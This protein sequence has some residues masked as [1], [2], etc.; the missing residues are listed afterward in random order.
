MMAQEKT[1]KARFSSLRRSL[2]GIVQETRGGTLPMVAALMIPMV[3]GVGLATDA[4]RGYIVKAR[5]GDALDAATLAAA[6]TV[7]TTSDIDADIKKYFDANFPPGFM[8]AN[9][10]L[11]PAVVSTDMTTISVSAA[12]TIDATF[13]KVVNSNDITV[14]SG[15]QVT[16]AISSID[17][18]LSIDMSGSM[19][20]D[21]GTGQTR[22][23]A[24]RT[25][26]HVLADTVFAQDPT[27]N[28]VQVGVVPWNGKV[29]ILQDGGTYNPLNVTSVT[30]PSY[31]NPVA[32]GTSTTVFSPD[33][34]PVNL[35]STPA[36][37]WSGCVYARYLN[38][39]TA[40]D[41]DDRL[42]AVTVNGKDWVAWEPI[43][44]TDEPA[45]NGGSCS[46]CTPCLSHGVTRMTNNTTTVSDAIDALV[47]PTGVTNIAQG[48][49][50]AGRMVSPGEPFNDANTTT[51]AGVHQKAIVLLTDGEQYGYYGDGYKVPWGTGTSA[52]PAG[53]DAR[54]LQ[55]ATAL[56]AQGVLIFTVQFY[57][58]TSALQNLMKSVASEPKAPYYFFA[59][60]GTALQSAFKEIANELSV[61]RISK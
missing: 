19:G 16:R 48:L 51:T 9:I 6:Q 7:A 3:A 37:S 35:F 49:I 18:V 1:L 36:A 33:I 34:T 31:T 4:A 46:Y 11:N 39:S 5:L 61:L 54:L 58:N 50:W 57:H 60:N 10:T 45:I 25:A 56:K 8:G 23:T 40:N 13:M 26:A 14:G 27:G 20:W 38:D 55:I 12:A 24:A 32:G 22:I 42:G 17:V 43:P 59:P 2:R 28:L 44:P 21:D 53:Q 30:V 52:G 47:S 29:N 41:A 15:S